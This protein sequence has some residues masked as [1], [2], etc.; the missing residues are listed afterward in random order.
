MSSVNT[1]VY[2]SLGHSVMP[3]LYRLARHGVPAPTSLP[4]WSRAQHQAAYNRGPHISAA[5]IYST[6]L[7][8]DRFN[9]VHE[10][11]WTILPFRAIQNL[12]ALKLSPAGVVPQRERQPRLILDYSFPAENNV[13]N[14]SLNLAPAHAMQF[15]KALPR[16]LQ[17]LVYCNALFGPPLILPGTAVSLCSTGACGCVTWG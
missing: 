12:P 5:K 6:F 1:R 15:G 9:M 7:L 3:Y 4:P 16:I 2:S 13:N 8:E 14:L 11:Y 17:R 10:G